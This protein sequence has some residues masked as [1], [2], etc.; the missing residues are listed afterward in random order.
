MITRKLVRITAAFVSMLAILMTVPVICYAA[1]SAAGQV[2]TVNGKVLTRQDLDREMKLVALKLAHQGRSVDSK[3]MK[4]YEGKI[5]ETLINRALLLEKSQAMG[6]SIKDAQVAKALI[7]FKGMFPDD[8]SYRKA[9]AD[10]GFSEATLKEKIKDGLTIKSLIDK[11]VLSN[12]S[13][14]D[15]AVRSYYDDNPSLFQQ[16]EQ[17]KASHIL[18]KV[19]PDAG[20]AQKNKART[21]I[22]S[23]KTRI[24]KGESF[25]TLAMENSDCPSK[26]KGGDLGFFGREQMVKPFSDA[27][28]VLEP[29]QT[30]D[31]VETRFGYHLIRVTDRKQER[32]M[33]Y[34]DVKAS[35]SARLRQQAEEKQVNTYLEKLKEHA[36]IKRFP[37]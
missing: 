25:A 2:A 20:E 29:G 33:A 12:V 14:S 32:T 21:A 16:P 9:L 35:I 22:E 11:E 17:V 27:A 1:D 8:K 26:A 23:L 19:S 13:V 15:K 7:E 6:V 28:F 31:V 18:V 37:L 5:R 36:D 10:M 30:S 24:D 3:Q 4:R 34:N